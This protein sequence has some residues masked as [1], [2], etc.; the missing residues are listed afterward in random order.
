MSLARVQLLSIVAG[1]AC[2]KPPL[3]PRR[4]YMDW[5]ALNSRAT[6]WHI[7]RPLTEAGREECLALKQSIRSAASE[8]TFIVD[9]FSAAAREESVDYES[10]DSG[11]LIGR[12]LRQGVCRDAE[13]DRACFCSPLGQVAGPIQSAEG[14]HLVLVEERL[15]LEMHDKG[16]ARVVSRPRASGKGVASVLAPADPEEGSELFDAGALTNLAASA[17]C[18]YVGG[19]LLSRWASSLDLEGLASQVQ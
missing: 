18:A 15:G 2:L 9:A 5:V 11:G 4:L 14:W 8:G 19:Q 16:M 7:M 13:L 10:R 1:V 12:R 17:G 6:T 3:V